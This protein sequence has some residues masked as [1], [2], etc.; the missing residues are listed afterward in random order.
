[1]KEDETYLMRGRNGQQVKSHMKFAHFKE[2][3]NLQG[4][5]NL[6][7][8]YELTFIRSFLLKYKPRETD[9][10]GYLYVYFRKVD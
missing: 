8:K 3:K 5:F 9:R 4:I 7:N 10:F 6:E 2:Q 1:L